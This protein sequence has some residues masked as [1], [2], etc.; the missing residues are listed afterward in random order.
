MP[1]DDQHRSHWIHL[2]GGRNYT[3]RAQVFGSVGAAWLVLTA[4]VAWRQFAGDAKPSGM[5]I[6]ILCVVGLIGLAVL[7]VGL[8]AMLLHINL[9]DAKVSVDH[10]ELILGRSFHVRV[11]QP[12]RSGLKI[13]QMRVA[14]VCIE[15]VKGK[16]GLRE[17]PLMEKW[18]VLTRERETDDR[19][20]LSATRKF[21]IPAESRASTPASQEQPPYVRWYIRLQTVPAHAPPYQAD[22]PIEVLAHGTHVWG[23]Q[24]SRRNL[25]A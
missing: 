3:R 20:N 10:R 23:E 18:E 7:A 24:P 17:I 14:L 25:Q 11:Q 5:W 9:G 21:E 13:K 1:P 19:H 12:V 22:F 16:G 2:S 6:A 4:L 8:H 15:M